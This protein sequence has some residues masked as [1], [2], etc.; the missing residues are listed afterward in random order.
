MNSKIELNEDYKFKF[1]YILNFF[2]DMVSE[3]VKVDD[4]ELNN[5]IEQIKQAQ[6]NL[7]IKG[8]EKDIELHEITKNKRATRNSTK[9]T[10]INN[11]EEKR[12][13]SIDKE[14]TIEDEKDR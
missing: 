9:N 12:I 7:H 10:K 1:S 2:K 6:D 5:K 4:N 8:L 14:I 13:D 3:S 11:V